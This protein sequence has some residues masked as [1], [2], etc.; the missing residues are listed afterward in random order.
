M[1]M[2]RKVYVE[3]EALHAISTII[4]FS[5]H[6]DGLSKWKSLTNFKSTFKIYIHSLVSKCLKYDLINFQSDLGP[7]TLHSI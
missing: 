2:H 3:F 4:T 7:I 6:D 5:C 1:P